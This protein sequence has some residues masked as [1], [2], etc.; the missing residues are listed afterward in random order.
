MPSLQ[1]SSWGTPSWPAL[2][3]QML[4]WPAPWRRPP[5]WREPSWRRVARGSLAGLRATGAGRARRLRAPRV[6]RRPALHHDGDVAGAPTD[7]ECAALGARTDPLGGR[8]VVGVDG[9][10]HQSRRVQAVVVLRVGGGARDDLGHRLA[11]RLRRPAQNVQRVGHR[12]AAYQ[13]DHPARLARRHPHEPRYGDRR[14]IFSSRAHRRLAFRSSLMC[15]LKVRVGANSP[16]LW[17]TI[18]SVTNTG[19]CLRPSWTANV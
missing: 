13:V 9:G 6:L 7:P 15:P 4:S 12:L 18:D 1:L 8:A 17:P 2:F 10:H 3:Q 19:T 16:S 5:S 14:R 11:G